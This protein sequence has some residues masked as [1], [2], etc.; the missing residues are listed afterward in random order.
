MFF[1]TVLLIDPVKGPLLNGRMNFVKRSIL[2]SGFLL[3]LSGCSSLMMGQGYRLHSDSKSEQVRELCSLDGE[4]YKGAEF[5]SKGISFEINFEHRAR[6]QSLGPPL[7]PLLPI[8]F[9]QEKNSEVFVT[10]NA[11]SK[12]M[13]TDFS[14]WQF[15]SDGTNWM[16]PEKIEKVIVN[17]DGQ[18]LTANEE[19]FSTPDLRP[20][21]VKLSSNLRMKD[22]ETVFIKTAE[23]IVGSKNISPMIL[24]W[25]RENYVRYTPMIG[26][27]DG[28]AKSMLSCQ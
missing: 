21:G 28:E 23:I 12:S 26:G 14:L 9:A 13:K 19:K 20:K 5:S 17:S 4:K 27:M 6:M 8:G 3:P 22:S 1:K 7:I 25:R 15:S 11:S 24:K 18:L 16:F 2:L 10:M